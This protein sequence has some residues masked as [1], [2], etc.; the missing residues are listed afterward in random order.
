[1]A[2]EKRMFAAGSYWYPWPVCLFNYKL[3]VIIETRINS[4]NIPS[5]KTLIVSIL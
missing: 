3:D 5:N 4:Y 1:M 2:M